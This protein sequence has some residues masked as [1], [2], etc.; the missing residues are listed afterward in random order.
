MEQINFNFLTYL[1]HEVG[2]TKM[3]SQ[4]YK[5]T[6]VENGVRHDF[7]YNGSEKEVYLM[8]GQ[9]NLNEEGLKALKVVLKNKGF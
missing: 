8:P 3:G 4:A 6:L 2:I 9:P 5:G 1:N 7:M